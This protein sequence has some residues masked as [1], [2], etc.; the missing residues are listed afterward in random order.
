MVHLN[1]LTVSFLSYAFWSYAILNKCYANFVSSAFFTGECSL[2]PTV[3]VMKLFALY[4][5]VHLFINS[6]LCSVCEFCG[7]L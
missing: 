2:W 3:D 4:K 7:I 1:E 5:I 6:N